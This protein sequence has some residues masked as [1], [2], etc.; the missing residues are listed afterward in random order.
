MPKQT[1]LIGHIFTKKVYKQNIFLMFADCVKERTSVWRDYIILN[2]TL[3][4]S[5]PVKQSLYI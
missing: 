2:L 5:N 4:I 3:S 1:S